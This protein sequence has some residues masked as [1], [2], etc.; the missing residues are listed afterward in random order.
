[1]EEILRQRHPDW[2]PHEYLPY[3]TL[4]WCTA[5]MEELGF[6]PYHAPLRCRDEGDGVDG[7][8]NPYRTIYLEL[9]YRIKRHIESGENPQL[10]VCEKPTQATAAV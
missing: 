10:G 4:A 7:F 3:D 1:M 6:D 8:K 9:R 2:N 5:Q